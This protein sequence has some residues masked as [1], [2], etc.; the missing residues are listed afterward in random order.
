MI[1]YVQCLFMQFDEGSKK[2]FF[3]HKKK[4]K[5]YIERATRKNYNQFGYMYQQL[6]KGGEVQKWLNLL[7]EINRFKNVDD[8]NSSNKN[9][10]Q[11]KDL[12]H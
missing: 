6:G 8:V 9:I 11:N 2:V 3:H 7:W 5:N 1:F 10:T 12:I 4:I